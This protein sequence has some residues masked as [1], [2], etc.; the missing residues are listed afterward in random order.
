MFSDVAS[1][2]KKKRIHAE[3]SRPDRTVDACRIVN[4][5]HAVGIVSKSG[6]CAGV[7]QLK[8][9]RFLA[10]AAPRFPLPDCD[11]QCCSCRYAHFDDRR[12]DEERRVSLHDTRG[13]HGTVE[14]RQRSGRRATD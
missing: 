6:S 12:G 11:M 14:R 4:P 8:G 2:I 1:W 10:R 13:N 9:H 7:T 5:Y 3:L